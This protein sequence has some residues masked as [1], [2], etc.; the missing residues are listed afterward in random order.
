MAK[1]ARKIN[2][3][4]CVALSASALMMTPGCE[5]KR[6]HRSSEDVVFAAVQAPLPDDA[7]P[8]DV[9]KTLLASL[10]ELH[11]T[12][13]SGLGTPDRKDH[14]DKTMGEIL[15]LAAQEHIHEGVK[16]K[17]SAIIPKNVT[18]NAAVRLVVESWASM[19]A[20]YVD[21]FLLETI[22]VLSGGKEIAS[23]RIQ[24]EN[25]RERKLLNE[26]EA[27]PEITETKDSS[28]NP[29]PKTSPDYL[30]LVRPKALAKGF[31]VPI[32]AELQFHLR[33]VDG[34]W[35][36]TQLSIGPVTSRTTITVPVNSPANP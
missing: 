32:R 24:V 4:W 10:K 30:K 28:G 33:R 20:H 31:N 19:V 7:A 18:K 6:R 1:Q 23:V 25:P 2:L 12:R 27:L 21:G 13:Q 35:R 34:A 15:S 11:S 8:D 5:D 14:Y 29:L 16:K 26:I 17:G 22:S 3:G 36:V 9:I